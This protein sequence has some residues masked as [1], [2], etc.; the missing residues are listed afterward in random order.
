VRHAVHAR[1]LAENLTEDHRRF[2]AGR[3]MRDVEPNVVLKVRDPWG[4]E[5]RNAGDLE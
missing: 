4:G 3:S 5:I 1:A 2:V